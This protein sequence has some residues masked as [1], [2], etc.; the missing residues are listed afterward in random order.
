MRTGQHTGRSPNDKFIV[1]EP[2]SRDKVWWGKINRPIDE[3]HF[4][5]ILAHQCSYLRDK[6]VYVQ[7]CYAART[8]RTGCG[9]V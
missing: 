5:R 7:D 6:E 1:D 2:S 3:E 4:E 9:S 8:R